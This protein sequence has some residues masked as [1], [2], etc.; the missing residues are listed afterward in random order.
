VTERALG[1]VAAVLAAAGIETPTQEF[2]SYEQMADWLAGA[3]NGA[4][5]EA[6]IRLEPSR[7]DPSKE[8]PTIKG[9][10]RPSA[11][12]DVPDNGQPVNGPGVATDDKPLPF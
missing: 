8:W 12:S 11:G 6:V 2:E 5:V 9:Y 10:R 7:K 3:L 4:T 1:N